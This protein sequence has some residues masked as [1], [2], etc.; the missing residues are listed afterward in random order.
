[1]V[2]W[3]ENWSKLSTGW[4]N[5]T[6]VVV[7]TFNY[8]GVTGMTWFA[9]LKLEPSFEQDHLKTLLGDTQRKIVLHFYTLLRCNWS[10]MVCWTEPWTKHWQDHFDNFGCCQE[11]LSKRRVPYLDIQD[12]FLLIFPSFPLFFLYIFCFSLSPKSQGNLNWKI[13][14]NSLKNVL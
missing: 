2:C 6:F 3:T 10:E 1:M 8:R 11:L 12:F 5:T 9:G 4:L 13:Y 14:K 7:N